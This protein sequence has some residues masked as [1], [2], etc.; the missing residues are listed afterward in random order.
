MNKKWI[1]SLLV[2]IF[3]V[4]GFLG[5]LDQYLSIGIWFQT[6]DIHHETLALMSFCLAIGVFIGSKLGENKS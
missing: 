5:L 6:R 2:L 4:I 3:L 1:S